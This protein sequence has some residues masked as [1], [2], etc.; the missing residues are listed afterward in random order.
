MEVQSQLFLT[1]VL[2]E[3]ECSVSRPDN[4]TPEKER[5]YQWTADWLGPR[6]CREQ[7]LF[8][9]PGIELRLQIAAV[10]NHIPPTLVYSPYTHSAIVMMEYIFYRFSMR[11]LGLSIYLILPAALGPGFD[12]ASSR[13]EYQESS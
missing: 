4:L 8:P 6:Q 10:P 3:S 9:L 2:D 11:Q 1:S 13:N 7:H 12:S 5:W